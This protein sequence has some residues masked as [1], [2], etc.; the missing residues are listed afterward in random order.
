MSI[1]LMSFST[2]TLLFLLVGVLLILGFNFF[3]R[4]TRIILGCVTTGWVGDL[5]PQRI[6]FS[7]DS[8]SCAHAEIKT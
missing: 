3:V 5:E 8:S 6:L 4:L 2:Q 1:R 7:F